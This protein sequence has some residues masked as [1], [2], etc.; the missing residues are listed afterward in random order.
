MCIR[1][2][3]T[4][5]QYYGFGLVNRLAEPGALSE[6]TADFVRTLTE[7]MPWAV[8]RT[9]ST[10]RLAEDM[11]LQGALNFGNQLNQLLR[12]NGQIAPVHSHDLET[13]RGLKS[14]ISE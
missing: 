1:D 14:D 3:Y 7:R 11:P 4:A 8:K 6:T 12:L 2:R 10:Y 5:E 13:K 9:K